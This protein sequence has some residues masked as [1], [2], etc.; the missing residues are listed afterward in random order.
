M[1]RTHHVLVLIPLLVGVLSAQQSTFDPFPVFDR[2]SMHLT[3]SMNGQLGASAAEGPYGLFWPAPGLSDDR[4]RGLCYSSTPVMVGRVNGEL[5]VS[6]S[7]YR[8]AFVTGPVIGG[9]PV[10]DPTDP[11]FRAYTIDWGN[12]ETTDYSEWPI[13]IGAPGTDANLPYFYGPSQMYWVMNDLDTAGMHEYN[14]N[15]PM[16]LEMRCLLYT[17]WP[18]AAREN[19]LLLQVTYINHGR[20]SIR[21]AYAGYFMDVELRDALNDLPG[22]DS[23]R[24]MVYA[25][26][27]SLNVKEEGLPVAFGIA[28]LQTPMVAAAG[29]S[30]RWFAG[31]K[32]NARNIPV[33][34]AVAPLKSSWGGAASEPIREPA[35]GSDAA[36]RWLALMQGRGSG[37][38]VIDPITGKPSRFWFSGDPASGEGWV[39]DDGL[40]LSDD[41]NI[42][43][44]A[45]DQRILISAGPFD[46][47]PGD[48]QQV[49]YAFIVAR[50]ASPTAAVHELRDRADFWKAAFR[51]RSLA[52]AYTSATVRPP[53]AAST[54]GQIEVNARV[55]A[56]AA[57]LRVEVTDGA[58][59]IIASEPLDRFTSG[60]DYL[61][62]KVL[63]LPT[64]GPAG[65]NVSFVAEA[66][67]ESLRLPGRVSMPISGS[68]DL[69]GIVMLE[70]GDDNGRV[71]PED[72]AKWFPRFV[73]RTA[74]VYEIFAQSALL[75]T[76][77]WLH[78]DPL[79]AN[80]VHPATPDAWQPENGYARLWAD[81]LVVGRDSILYRYDLYD[82][83]RNVL[84]ERQNWIPVDSAA[85]EWYDVLMTQVRGSSDER[86][87]VRLVD[88]GALQDK[89]YVL[90]VSGSPMDRRLAL[91][92]STT[93]VAYFTD[94]G[95]DVFQGA[96]PVTD[97]FRVVRGT[98]SKPY[99]G[100]NAV[101][102]ADLYVF[103]PRH[104]MLARS[105]KNAIN[106]AVVSRPSP[107]PLTEWT[108]VRVDLPASGTLR[109]EV[110]NLIG[111]RVKV[112]RDGAVDAGRHL[113]LWDGYWSDGRPAETGMYLLRI[114]AGGGEVTRKIIVLR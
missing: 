4:T 100:T 28:M 110:W 49:T 19:T 33:T 109:A 111:Q 88:L 96:L 27:G 11:F 84:W 69:E 2:G 46:F 92:D 10:V 73:N 38:D 114:V 97:G 113:L 99:A 86:P 53:T 18:G 51:E 44:H 78:V 35:L 81:S 107:M 90:S 61:Y 22:S 36:E 98:I 77:Q 14:G 41:R 50:G 63:V 39:P 87:G 79:P 31:W 37:V 112:L 17:P 42:S 58:G 29:D 57:D 72:D 104:V 24:D 12:T 83:A 74:H 43:Q 66:E 106:D 67:G 54:P 82:P 6:A 93:G 8:D 52:T 32:N 25:Y 91:H 95:L 64:A 70:E 1:R 21:D 101:T 89:W 7:Y 30:A 80:S 5:R 40:L 65:V 68:V 76:A 59:S 56:L 9:K 71:A 75:P 3:I 47:A 48:T 20:D 45:A 103:N 62:R 23:V 94:Y 102:N 15:D 108:S 13:S 55:A 34:A 105:Q 60:S 26:Q 16:G 85:E